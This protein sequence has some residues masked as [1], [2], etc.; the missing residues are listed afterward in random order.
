MIITDSR[1]RK[2][3]QSIDA[4]NN[5]GKRVSVK[6]Y[7]GAGIPRLTN[8]AVKHLTKFPTDAIIFMGC[9]NNLTERNEQTGRFHLTI[10]DAATL[11]KH[12]TT[13]IDETTAVLKAYFPTAV[14]V[15][16]PIIGL[17]L[18]TYL[19]DYNETHQ[20]A[21]DTTVL[22]LNK[23]IAGINRDNEIPTP[24]TA[25]AVHKNRH[26]KVEHNYG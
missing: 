10:A 6:F 11:T 13:L 16:A 18:S 14:V 1:G 21:V 19:K 24:W 5:T 2:L 9:V 15:Y 3:Q 8:M 26:R 20:E 7:P 23:H 12:L 25:A 17:S 4:V 22:R